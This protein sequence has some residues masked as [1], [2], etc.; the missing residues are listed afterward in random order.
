MIKEFEPFK[1]KVAHNRGNCRIWIEGKKLI[2]A[3]INN[4]D[5]FD[6]RIFPTHVLLDFHPN[7][8]RKV[9]GKPERPIIDINTARLNPLFD[10]V[11]HYMVSHAGYVDSL[12]LPHVV[13]KPHDEGS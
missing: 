3:N 4:G 5:R 1:R 7:G 8:E 13:I 6:C 11:S 12:N 10:S 9:S 2:E